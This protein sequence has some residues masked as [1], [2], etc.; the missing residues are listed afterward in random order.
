MSFI[1]L[2]EC[3]PDGRLIELTV[4]KSALSRSVGF[5]VPRGPISQVSCQMKM[6]RTHY[7]SIVAIGAAIAPLAVE[8]EEP[9]SVKAA[10]AEMQG[11]MGGMPSVMEV[12]P[13]SAISAGWALVKSTDPNRDAALPAKASLWRWEACK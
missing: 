5:S 2:S 13:K 8:A 3:S 12:Y 11:M 1:T 6:L 7:A 4:E 10:Y 9:A